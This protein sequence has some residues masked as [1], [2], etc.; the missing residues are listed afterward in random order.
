MRRPG[1]FRGLA[2]IL[3]A[4]YLLGCTGP[5]G[6]VLPG[7][8]SASPSAPR[9][10]ALLSGIN[11]LSFE[12]LRAGEGYF[13]RSGD[14]LIFQSERQESNPFYQIYTLDLKKGSVQRV[15]PGIGKATCGWIHPGSRRALFAST[16]LDP[17]SQS[18]QRLELERRTSGQK[19]RYAWDYDPSYDLFSVPLDAPGE[20]IPQALTRSRG[21]DAEGSWSPNGRQILFASNRHAYAEGAEVDQDL[22]A[23]DPSY[24]IDL[25][26]MDSSGQNIRRLTDSPGYDGGPFFS[27]GGDRIV[28]RRFS[29]DGLTAEIYSMA[30]DG[31]EIRQLTRLGVLSWAP[32][33]HP[34]GDYVIFTTNVH[35]HANFELYIVDVRG[36]G[37]PVRVTESDGFDGLPAFSPEGEELVWT[38]NRTL[39][40]RSQLFRAR[41]GDAGAREALGLPARA[42]PQATALLPLPKQTD[43]AIREADLRAHVEALASDITEGRLTGTAGEKIAT[44]Y[45]ARAFRAVGLEPAG[46]GGTYFQTFGFT[47]GISLGSGNRL[48]ISQG[49]ARR[50]LDRGV[51]VEW[52]PFAFSKEGEV[53]ASGIVW[54]GYGIVAP[55]GQGQKPID[56]YSGLDVKGR[57]V[58]VLRHVP[59]NLSAESRQHLHRYSSLRYKAMLAR[60]RGARGVLVVS[61][62]NSQVRDELVPLGFDVSLAGTSIAAISID[63]ALAGELLAGSEK[64]LEA[65]HDEADS[66]SSVEGFLL[67]G[68]EVSAEIALE[69][70]RRTGRNVIGRLQVG[71]QPSEEI[72]LVGAHVDHLGRGENAASLARNDQSASIHP[73]ADDNA[74]GVASL[75][76]VAEVTASGI[77]SGELT[78]RRDL[79]FAAWSGEELGLLGSSHWVG[80][81]D[82]HG[83]QSAVADKVAAYLNF[84]MV[85]RMG[86]FLSLYGVGSS[87]VWP[88]EIERAN[89]QRA[90]PILPQE[91]SQLPTDATVFFNRGV[92]VLAAFTGAHS[93]YHTPGDTPE[94]LDYASMEKIAALVGEVAISL[95]ENPE[96]PR[97]IAPEPGSTAPGPSGIRVYL[98]T[99]PDYAKSGVMGLALAG[100][101]RGGPAEKGGLRAGDIVVEIAG[102]PIENIY[103]YT[104]ALDALKVQEPIRVVVL[105][106]DKR[107]VLEVVPLSRD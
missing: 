20:T 83:T 87:P 76:E 92:P 98:G 56:N 94:K 66:A 43:E 9:E 6:P 53:P 40:G 23:R 63:D 57:W 45:V 106:G 105:R 46:D 32:F 107:L 52:R 44:S 34:S 103:D 5:A 35:G 97:F 3:F 91:E 8:P 64:S 55:A 62:P 88:A 79:V 102:T 25:Y 51:D 29:P 58:L 90:L 78:G 73:G 67:P 18:E 71:P 16:H 49:G 1:A 74:S 27:P 30:T 75:I 26:I 101:T 24:F 48:A 2:P 19:R 65:L 47:A 50:V 31:S 68:V 84:D 80:P 100:V 96:R 54:A 42:G 11:Q 7:S 36:E 59:S 99:L 33:Y 95:S 38:S 61:G 70:Q 82:P 15:S 13:S 4:L 28:W 104:Y 77:A 41:W 37:E 22:L 85:G 60:D 21:Y 12:G 86:D 10:K 89:I 81:V 72:I 69:R 39:D 93:D 14:L 17:S